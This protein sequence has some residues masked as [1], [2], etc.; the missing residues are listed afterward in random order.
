MSTLLSLQ[1][2]MIAAL[3]EDRPAPTLGLAADMAERFDIY[4]NNARLGWADLLANAYP[5]VKAV[6]GDAF[7][8]GLAHHYQRYAPQPCGNRHHFGAHLADFLIDFAPAACLPYLPALARLEWAVFQAELAQDAVCLEFSTLTTLLESDPDPLLSL[9]PAVQLVACDHDILDIWRGHHPPSS[10]DAALRWSAEAVTLLVWRTRH[11]EV[12][13]LSP[14]PAL[15][16]LCRGIAAQQGLATILSE[17]AEQ[18]L[19]PA[20][21]QQALAQAVAYGL[22]CASPFFSLQG[23]QL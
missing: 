14:T 20:L 9:H 6:V 18:N 15:I 17:L 12:S 13:V 10:G 5:V 2:D 4:R 23:D 11:D 22:L 8:N 3:V 1:T 7:L 16:G 21:I 19:S